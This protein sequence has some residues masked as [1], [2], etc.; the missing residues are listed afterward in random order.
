VRFETVPQK[1]RL[2]G[3]CQAS[4]SAVDTLFLTAGAKYKISAD[5][6]SK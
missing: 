4:E 3:L 5:F 2:I 1:L 6:V